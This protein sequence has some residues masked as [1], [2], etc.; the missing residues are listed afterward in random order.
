LKEPVRIVSDLHLGHP[1]SRIDEVVKWLPLLDGV[2]TLVI[3]GDACEQR[4]RKWKVRGDEQLEFLKTAA[5]HRGVELILLRGNH[6]PGVSEIDYLE[7]ADGAMVVTHGDALFRHLS[8][9][10]PKVMKLRD[11]MDA[12]WAEAETDTLEGWFSA[13][14]SCR[15]LKPGKRDEADELGGLGPLTVPLR[16][17][18]PPWRV[19]MMLKSWWQAPGVA[20]DFC[21][22]F[23]PQAKV[24]VFGH[25]HW[26]GAWRRGGRTV[27]NAGG[28]LSVGGSRVVDVAERRVS[29]RKVVSG[30]GGTF[31]VREKAIFE[32]DFGS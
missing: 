11:E 6:D 28:Y 22:R 21:E 3:N 19:P 25:T 5:A 17:V 10:S 8:P 4:Y 7:L 15:T 9:W 12:V 32:C 16:L 30:E 31:A 13:V 26:P 1:A 23:F 29:V 27:M 20:R 24:M 14:Q 2:G 18:W